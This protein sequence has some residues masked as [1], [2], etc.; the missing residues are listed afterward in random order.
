MLN[1]EYDDTGLWIWCLMCGRAGYSM[2]Y[3]R[4]REGIGD[5]RDIQLLIA[6]DADPRTD[7]PVGSRDVESRGYQCK[8]CHHSW[9]SRSGTVPRQCPGQ[10][11]RSLSWNVAPELPAAVES[12]FLS[13][14]SGACQR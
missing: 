9:L 10:Y 7:Y 13:K 12:P 11:C 4:V 3:E 14:P 6:N 2:V 8:I 1:W 5:R